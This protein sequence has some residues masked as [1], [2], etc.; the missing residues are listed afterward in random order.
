MF[1]LHRTVIYIHTRQNSHLFFSLGI[2]IKNKNILIEIHKETNEIITHS[3]KI[4]IPLAGF[5][6]YTLY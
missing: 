6:T 1:N 5:V 4:K 3:Q 2:N